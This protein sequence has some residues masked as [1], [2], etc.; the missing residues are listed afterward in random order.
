MIVSSLVS[1]VFDVMAKEVKAMNVNKEL[2][3][4]LAEGSETISVFCCYAGAAL[5]LMIEKQIKSIADPELKVLHQVK[6]LDL[7]H[8]TLSQ[9]GSTHITSNASILKVII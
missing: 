5:H 2:K 9:G 7:E 3:A 4:E 8:D 6:S 1:V